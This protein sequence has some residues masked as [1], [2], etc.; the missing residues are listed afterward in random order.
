MDQRAIRINAMQSFTLLRLQPSIE[1]AC[2]L[3]TPERCQTT[4]VNNEFNIIYPLKN[5]QPLT[6]F[7]KN[8]TILKDCNGII[9]KSIQA[10]NLL[11][12]LC[13]IIIDE[14]I[15]DN[16][17][18][19]FEISIQNVSKITLNWTHKISFQFRYLKEP[20]SILQEA[21][22]LLDQPVYFQ[23]TTQIIHQVTSVLLFCLV[24]LGII[25]FLRNKTRISELLY[26]PRKI[27]HVEI[28]NTRELSNNRDVIS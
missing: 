20:T 7:K 18:P 25:L 2:M 14:T 9:F 28:E 3:S 26:K 6:L 22:R 1:E 11:S 12:S 8:H 21:E 4:P 23:P 13:K 27:L 16:T 17:T 24:I 19:I 10:T 15:F 5:H